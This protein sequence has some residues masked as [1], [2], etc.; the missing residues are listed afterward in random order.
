M[1]R[2]ACCN[3]PAT[4]QPVVL[5]P[6]QA[7]HLE[8]LA[9]RT[10][11]HLRRVPAAPENAMGRRLELRLSDA[12]LCDARAALQRAHNWRAG[13]REEAFTDTTLQL[14]RLCC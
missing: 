13:D 9:A 11:G 6:P 5:P 1:R 12:A 8:H 2:P 7:E 3:G 4:E 14:Q 10:R